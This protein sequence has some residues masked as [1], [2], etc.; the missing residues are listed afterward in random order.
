MTDPNLRPG[1]I[2]ELNDGRIGTIRF[3]GETTFR[4]GKW[5]GVELEDPSGKN[6]GSVQGKRYFDCE[7]GYGM[8]LQPSG[9]GRIIE[10]APAPA[11]AP[12]PATARRPSATPAT[13]KPNGK[14]AVPAP[15]GRTASVAS[16]TASRPASRPSSIASESQSR[17]SVRLIVV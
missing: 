15:K 6:D 2:V 1:A 4:P 14:A 13:A 7:D 16:A 8:F 12:K 3:V 9:V 11:P 5:V 10:A 17:T